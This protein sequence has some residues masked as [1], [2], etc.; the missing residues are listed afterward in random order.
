MLS[1]QTLTGVKISIQSITEC[2]KCLLG[3]GADF[4]LTRT[5]NQDPLEQ[6]FGHYRHGA[7]D[8]SNPTVYNVRHMMT[9]MRAVAAQSVVIFATKR[10]LPLLL[11]LVNCQNEGVA[12]YKP[13]HRYLMKISYTSLKKDLNF[14]KHV[15]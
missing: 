3:E 9:Q 5:F 1:R 8:N 6:H 11:T 15:I 10:M 4:I 7:G 12:L 13:K 14:N 2:V